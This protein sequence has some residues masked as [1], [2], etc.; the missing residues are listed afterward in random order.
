LGL[1]NNA[2]RYTN[3]NSDRNDHRPGC[4]YLQPL[5]GYSKYPEGSPAAILSHAARNQLAWLAVIGLGNLSSRP[6]IS[7]K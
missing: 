3:R 5:A 6:G 2:T 7:I 1:K 4:S